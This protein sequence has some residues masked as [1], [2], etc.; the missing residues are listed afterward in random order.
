MRHL[1]SLFDL[2]NDDFHAIIELAVSLKS[3]LAA[4]ERPDFLRNRTLALI[5]EKA[6]LR[7][8]VSFEAGMAQ[9]GGTAIYLT[10]DAGWRERESIADFVRV[11]SEYCDFVVCRA[12]SQKTVNELAAHDV[13][14]VINGLTDESH[15][16]QA[17]GDILTMLED[18]RGELRGKQLTFLGDGN[19]VVR[20]LIKATHMAG[21]RFRLACPKPYQVHASFLDQIKDRYGETD[22]AQ[23][24]D[25]HAMVRGADYLYT[26]VWTSMGQETENEIRK[27]A[28]SPYQLNQS[29]LRHAPD[30]CKILHCLPARRGLEVTDEVLDSR[31]SI[32]FQQAG[33]RL[34]AQKGL[35][36]WLAMQNG[37]LDA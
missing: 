30:N 28:F 35:L 3:R 1:R 36:V 26:D 4:G 27:Q 10:S 20:S 8:R 17:L 12:I 15:P 31:Q 6:S 16:C 22:F 25:I 34:H 18:S 2:S 24:E 13:L 29:V 23:S 7:T 11:L 5:F 32:V 9:L 14:P 37:Y 19:N 21:M 33:N